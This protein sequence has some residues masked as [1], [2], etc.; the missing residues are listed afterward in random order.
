M[1][2]KWYKFPTTVRLVVPA[3]SIT[4]GIAVFTASDATPV[5]PATSVAVAVT[6]CVPPDSAAGRVAPGAAGVGRCGAENGRSVEQLDGAARFRGAGQLQL[7]G[8]DDAVAG[9]HRRVGRDGVDGHVERCRRADIAG[10]IGRGHGEVMHAVGE[11][12]GGE[13]P[14]LGLARAGRVVM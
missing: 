12:R 11:R 13:G 2:P 1:S 4:L 3:D 10:G 9:D 5:L 7:V 14:G 6:T 8:V